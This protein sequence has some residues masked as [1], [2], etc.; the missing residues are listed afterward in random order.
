[1]LKRLVNWFLY[2]LRLKKRPASKSGLESLLDVPL[3]VTAA[4]ILLEVVR[5]LGLP[6]YKRIL[7][8]IKRSSKL[9]RIIVVGY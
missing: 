4:A 6:W 1:M 5:S 2:T 7:L 3:V 8:Y 9:F